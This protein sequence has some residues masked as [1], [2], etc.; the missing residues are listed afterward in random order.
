MGADES[1]FEAL[2]NLTDELIVAFTAALPV[3]ELK[4]AIPTGIALGLNK[5]ETFI[6]AYIGSLLPVPIL[7]AFFRP[8][9]AHLHRTRVFRRFASWV[10]SRT[11]HKGYKLRQYSLLGLFIFV[12]IPLPTTGVWTGSMIASFFKLKF[13]HAFIIIALGNLVAG[14][15]VM[16]I[17][18]Q[19][20]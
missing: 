17:S 4:G 1:M 12:A 15:L 9:M 7:L 5:W 2:Q 8:I 18:H 20:V 16:F 13:S 3:I 19:F 6:S 11:R 10:Y 14:L